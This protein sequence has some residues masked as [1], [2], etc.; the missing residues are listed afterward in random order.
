MCY[1]PL[2]EVV[3]DDDVQFTLK[4]LECMCCFT[5]LLRVVRRS[6]F[7]FSVRAMQKVADAHIWQETI[8]GILVEEDHYAAK[9]MLEDLRLFPDLE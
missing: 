1:I 6:L 4:I 3:Y 2:K 9:V 5:S 8:L 7:A